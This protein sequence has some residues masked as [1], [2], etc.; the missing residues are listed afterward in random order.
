MTT[1]QWALVISALALAV[2]IGVPIWQ[3]RAT[4]AQTRA[5]RRA[6]L[7]QTILDTKTTTYVTAQELRYLLERYG[8]RMSA[9]QREQLSA[10]YPRLRKHCT[11][12]EQLH[13]QWCNFSD[14]ASFNEI[15]EELVQVNIAAAE[16][17]ETAQLVEN[18]RRSHEEALYLPTNRS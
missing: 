1:E 13:E 12:L 2:S 5:T 7:L 11:D 14:G 15:E 9:A 17:R 8:E 16:A 3:C 6:L 10:M 4:D 18:G